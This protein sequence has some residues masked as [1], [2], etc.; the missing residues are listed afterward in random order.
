MAIGI[1]VVFESA[2]ALLAGGDVVSTISK[3]IV[4]ASIVND[5]KLFAMV[6]ISAL[7]AGALWLHLATWIGAPVSTTHS[8]VGGVLGAAVAAVGPDVVNWSVMSK[9]AASWVIS[10]LLGGVIA[11]L[12]L[13]QIESRIFSSVD[14]RSAFRRYIPVLI[15]IMIGVFSI[16]LVMKGL[17]KL[18]RPEPYMMVGIGVTTFLL[19]STI[20]HPIVGRVSQSMQN[21]RYGVNKL[22]KIPLIVAAVFLSFA[23]GSNDVANAI[24][25]MAAIVNVLT[26]DSVSD[27]VGI[28]LWVMLIG[29]V[30]I[31]FGLALFGTKMIQTVGKKLT[32]LDQSRAFCICL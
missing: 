1:A 10:P 13:S 5:T 27:K 28:P 26:S 17:K 32:C 2:G 16:Y 9:I 15:G 30:G 8:I 23:H 3:N 4:D 24:G 11:A 6:M 31:A 21:R 29:A 18:W 20:L 19:V 7:V 12:L 14:M 22:F 25:P